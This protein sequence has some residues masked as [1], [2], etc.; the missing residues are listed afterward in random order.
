MFFLLP[1]IF[2]VSGKFGPV[3]QADLILQT[4]QGVALQKKFFNTHM[5]PCQEIFMKLPPIC[6]RPQNAD[7]LS[8]FSGFSI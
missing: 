1:D 2:P 6:P 8:E 5:S 4:E 3:L 7:R